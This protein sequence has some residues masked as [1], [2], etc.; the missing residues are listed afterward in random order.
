MRADSNIAGFVINSLM[1]LK[2]S[3]T[4]DVVWPSLV[5]LG[6]AVTKNVLIQSTIIRAYFILL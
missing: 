3:G 1:E 6:C 4:L 2:R 5:C